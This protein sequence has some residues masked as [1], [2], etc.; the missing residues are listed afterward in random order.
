[1]CITDL[2]CF[3]HIA[4][5]CGSL[6]GTEQGQQRCWGSPVLGWLYFLSDLGPEGPNS[7]LGHLCFMGHTWLE[8]LA[9]VW[10]PD[11]FLALLNQ[12]FLRR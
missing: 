10:S 9:I 11:I 5:W 1:M 6:W 2:Q 3:R 12:N 7:S 8:P 4:H